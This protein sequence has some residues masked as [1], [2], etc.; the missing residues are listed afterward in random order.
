LHIGERIRTSE[1]QIRS[2]TDFVTLH[3]GERILCARF[4]LDLT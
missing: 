1:V 3:I 4:R 2:H